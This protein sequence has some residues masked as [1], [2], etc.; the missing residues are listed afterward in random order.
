MSRMVARWSSSPVR[1]LEIGSGVGFDVYELAHLGARCFDV[2][3]YPGNAEF[4]NACS[5]FYGL[6]IDALRGD[7]CHLPFNDEC[8]DAVYSKSTFEHVWDPDRALHEQVRVLKRSGRLLIYD[9]NLFNPKTFLELFLKRFVRSRGREGGLKWFFNKNK[10]LD[11]FGLGWRGKDED[12][13]TIW[14]WRKKIRKVDGIDLIEI[15]TTRAYKNPHSFVYQFLK[16]L[17]G[18]IIVLG[19]K[20]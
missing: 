6:P 18:G 11:N 5:Q 10:V 8:F 2:D 17:A 12:V 9:G 1:I 13:K 3:L 16:P 7:T 4:V 19:R 20:K 15:S 14:W